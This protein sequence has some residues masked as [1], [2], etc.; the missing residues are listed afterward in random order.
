[1][2]TA[3]TL[4]MQVAGTVLSLMGSGQAA[5]GKVAAADA[6]ATGLEYRAQQL[7]QKAGQEIASSQRDAIEQRRRQKLVS[8]RALALG[9]ASGGGIDPG[10]ADILG[11]LAEEGE[12][13]V[14]TSLYTG[15]EKAAG[16]RMQAE[17]D[18]YE[19][20][21]FRRAGRIEAGATRTAGFGAAIP[22]FATALT[23]AK[24]L[25]QKYS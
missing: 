23:D 5:D 18:R 22:K 2:G 11:G 24:S 7:E 19:A 4:P 10:L 8:S 12:F 21:E 20:G 6:R 15:D 17:A 1:M 25:Y 13:R 16:L 9:A 14:L 3:V